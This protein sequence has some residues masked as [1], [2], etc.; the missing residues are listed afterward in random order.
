M[1]H[2]PVDEGEKSYAQGL[3]I[4]ALH[5]RVSRIRVDVSMIK[6]PF[7]ESSSGSGRGEGCTV[8]ATGCVMIEDQIGLLKD[9]SSCAEKRPF[10]SL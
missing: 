9:A 5:E 7:A 10:A 3:S 8:G 4:E 1:G 6:S 2:A